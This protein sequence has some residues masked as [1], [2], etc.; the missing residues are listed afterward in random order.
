MDQNHRSIASRMN[1]RSTATNTAAAETPKTKAPRV[2]S[3]A[4]R[5]RLECEILPP[6]YKLDTIEGLLNAHYQFKKQWA[7][8]RSI[9]WLLV[10]VLETCAPF[11]AKLF[12]DVFK[13]YFTDSTCIPPVIPPVIPVLQESGPDDVPDDLQPAPAAGPDVSWPCMRSVWMGWRP[14]NWNLFL[15]SRSWSDSD[16]NFGFGGFC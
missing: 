8:Y 1:S 6:S 14:V 9:N 10:F 7:I 12:Y 2:R 4:D 3:F 5:E 13:M 16:R 11:P 15:H